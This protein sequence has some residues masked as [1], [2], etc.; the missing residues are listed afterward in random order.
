MAAKAKGN[1]FGNGTLTPYT[2]NVKGKGKNI[3][4]P[5]KSGKGSKSK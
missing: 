2:G 1:P 5:A 3:P 4:K